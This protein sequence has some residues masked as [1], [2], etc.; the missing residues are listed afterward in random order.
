M[1]LAQALKFSYTSVAQEIVCD[2]DTIVGLC[3]ILA[4]IFHKKAQ[5]SCKSL[6]E[7]YV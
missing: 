7:W 3:D 1:E 5:T 2:T 6:I 4:R